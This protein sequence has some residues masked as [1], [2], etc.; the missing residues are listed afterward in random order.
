MWPG[1]LS[2]MC[3]CLSAVL[4]TS[5]QAAAV[6]AARPGPLRGFGRFTHADAAGIEAALEEEVANILD[7]ADGPL[8]AAIL[9]EAWVPATTPERHRPPNGS[10]NRNG[11]RRAPQQPQPQ[12]PQQ[13]QQRASNASGGDRG[14][15]GSGER[16]RRRR[17]GG[18][19]GEP[20]RRARAGD[21]PP[22]RRRGA[23]SSARLRR[24]R[25]VV[26]SS[27]RSARTKPAASPYSSAYH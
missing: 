14:T 12:Q 27:G 18:R 5:E 10:G 20:R 19:G 25:G 2:L 23:A 7:H 15:R 13:Q 26:S 11:S 6:P 17:S 3:L 1:T 9:A 22:P 4:P 8:S 24:S 16:V 21:S